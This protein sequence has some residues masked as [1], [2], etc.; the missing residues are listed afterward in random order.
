MRRTGLP[1]RLIALALIA[2]L[3]GSAAP[4]GAQTG[5]RPARSP[6]AARPPPPCRPSWRASICSWPIWPSG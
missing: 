6:V 2:A 4:L 5:E 1:A 3:M